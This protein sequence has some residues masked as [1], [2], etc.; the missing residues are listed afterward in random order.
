[1]DETDRNNQLHL[2]VLKN[3][4]FSIRKINEAT[5][6]VESFALRNDEKMNI[7]LKYRDH[8]LNIFTHQKKMNT[9]LEDILEDLSAGPSSAG[10]VSEREDYGTHLTQ[11]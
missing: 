5:K 1:M 3:I 9:T 6:H 11:R 7:V 2:H 10:P 4:D 8:M